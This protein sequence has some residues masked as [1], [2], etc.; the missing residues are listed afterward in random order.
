MTR[1]T[2]PL[3]KIVA[4]L[5]LASCAAHIPPV[6]LHRFESGDLQEVRAFFDEQIRHGDVQSTALFLNG[7]A[8]IELLEGELE[9]AQRHFLQAGQIMGN[10]STPSSEVIAAI[11]GAESSKT[12]KGDPHEKFMNAFYSGLLDW[13][14]GE[15]DNAR[16]CFKRGILAD[17][18]SDEGGSQTDCAL[19][20]W[21]AGRMSSLMGLGEDA[22]DYFEEAR[23][24]RRFAVDHGAAGART[25]PVLDA[26]LAGNLVCLVAL[27]LGP[28]KYATGPHGSI[29]EILPRPGGAASAE[30]FLDGESLGVSSLLCDLDYQARTRG[31]RAIE[32]I[33]RGKAVLKEVSE[34]AAVVLI[35]RALSDSSSS[36]T[37]DKLLVGLGLLAL[38]W[39]TNSEADLRHWATLPRSV[40]VL[41]A[42]VDPGEYELRVAFS[43]AAGRRLPDLEQT[44][45][46][47]VP[48]SGEGV[49]YFR[50]LP[51]LDR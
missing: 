3:L 47:E 12:W 39:M 48:D 37:R 34:V 19:L 50:S 16:A 43:D 45:R 10:W 2:H 25:N 28:A 32:G 49:Y 26:P 41:T 44:W 31:G 8:Q 13:F 30:L 6:P 38:S 27:G 17:A 46:V 18:E 36:G 11:I 40:H 7:L 9:R 29:A 35:D 23:A 4:L 22:A 15:P 42:D 33:R 51:A 21:L 5:A 20:F 1:L 14:G 24:A